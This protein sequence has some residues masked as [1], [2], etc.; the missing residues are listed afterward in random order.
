ME[1][2][3]VTDH[4]T[5]AV[6][7]GKQAINFGVSDDAALM[8][9]LSK[10]LYTDPELAVIRETLCNGWDAH[11]ESSN[12]D[13][14]LH[15]IL[16]EEELVIRDFGN[17]IPHRL[18]RPVYGTYGG[19]T[20]KADKRQTGGF[21]LGCKSPFAYGDHFEVTSWS[22]EDKT[23]TVYNMSKSNAEVGGRPAIVP[24]VTVP[25]T[26]Q[27]L[28]VRIKLNQ[29]RDMSRFEILIKR[30]ARNG[31]MKVRFNGSM[32]P[33]L[34]FN[35]MQHGW[36]I[37]DQPLIETRHQI[38]V[39]YGHVIYPVES[40]ES[41][42]NEFSKIKKILS[43]I[44][45]SSGYRSN[46]DFKIIFQAPASEISITPSREA[47]SMQEGTVSIIKRVLQDFI[48]VAVPRIEA[49]CHKVMV[50]CISNTWLTN[51]PKVLFE[52]EGKIAN[53]PIDRGLDPVMS[54]FDQF[55]TR[56]AS[57]RYPDYPNFKHKEHLQRLD[58]LIE[59]GF[60]DRRLIKSF[61]NELAAS[62]KN[63]K[64]DEWGNID[65]GKAWF[66]RNM[67][68][69][70]IKGMQA[71]PMMHEDKLF[72]RAK[73][74]DYSYGEVKL[75][76][77][78]KPPERKMFGY[79][80]FLR[81]VVILAHNRIDIEDR[82]RN[83]PVM[84]HWL[85]TC[86]DVFVYTVARSPK[87]VEAALAFFNKRGFTVL[88]L[89]KAQ[90]WEHIEAAATQPRE[91]PVAPR[92]KGIPNL[93]S[94]L[95][96]TGS[97]NLGQPAKVTENL[98][99]DPKFVI[100]YSPKAQENY[101]F[102]NHSQST[103]LF[104]INEWGDEG[105]FVVNTNQQEK[106][107][108][109]GAML[110]VDFILEKIYDQFVKNPRIKASLP[111]MY[112]H[113]NIIMERSYGR[114]DYGREQKILQAVY[115]DKDLVEYFGL[116]QSMTDKDKMYFTMWNEFKSEGLRGTKGFYQKIEDHLAT[117]LVDKQVI[118][119]FDMIRKSDVLR[120]LNEGFLVDVM[121]STSKVTP[122]RRTLIRD[123]LLQAIEG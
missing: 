79:V 46:Q 97:M 68:W 115:A 84:K 96:V 123:M 16:T 37:T 85:G 14:A 30:I 104:I 12:T 43:S 105:G 111:Y 71:D 74:H 67:V 75:L 50:D 76:G 91:Y 64:R 57:F 15:V 41:Y 80:K 48:G 90:P 18:I 112:I 65:P 108:G 51:A 82:A 78:K 44:P 13:K 66:Y 31:E 25:T 60:G 70:L 52:T 110:Y 95:T 107:I 92:R 72:M 40:H 116:V 7:G 2:S 34:P 11:V 118:N 98:L 24:I 36:L 39:R 99:A 81:K 120:A 19:S 121:T 28:Q 38:L 73:E 47:L 49:G 54:S 109:T 86:K 106:Y 117:F 53:L 58:A 8:N 89:T 63:P 113:S 27:G 88:D 23:M 4:V 22:V 29:K 35:L 59:A 9:V 3:Q 61:R 26:E 119:L 69:P 102:E 114:D 122:Q 32:I 1:V 87:K 33:V 21:G 77:Y 6:I 10:A 17:G 83:F 93:K 55:I 45:N 20:K 56:Y 42:A 103:S 94:A 5:N 100:K 62:H 101:K